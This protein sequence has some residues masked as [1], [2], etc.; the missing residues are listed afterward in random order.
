MAFDF[1]FFFFS[2][3][4]K[5]WSRSGEIHQDKY[6]RFYKEVIKYSTNIQILRMTT[7]N[8]A[9]KLSL[10]NLICYQKPVGKH[11]EANYK[12][13][14]SRLSKKYPGLKPTR[15]DIIRQLSEYYDLKGIEAL[16]KEDIQLDEAMELGITEHSVQGAESISDRISK[17]FHRDGDEEDEEEGRKRRKQ[18]RERSRSRVKGKK[19]SKKGKDDKNEKEVKKEVKT[20]GT[21]EEKKEDRGEDKVTKPAVTQQVSFTKPEVSKASYTDD[22]VSIGTRMRERGIRG[23][24]DE[25][26][27]DEETGK[28]GRSRTPKPVT[29][30]KTETG[31]ARRLR[32][33]SR[34]GVRTESSG[35]S[36]ERSR[37][38]SASAENS[39]GPASRTRHRKVPAKEKKIDK[40]QSVEKKRVEKK[41]VRTKED[42]GIANRT[43]RHLRK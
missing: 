20:E 5:S 29:G 27:E 37:S 25:E 14:A 35:R 3:S 24:S 33:S 32:S 18:S 13:I 22:S 43:R 11:R 26:S 7:W 17:R 10:L 12:A 4:E 42:G 6:S 23:R 36:R 34:S 41:Q 21:A 28:R 19:S 9:Q 1:F 8:L 38:R 16:D 15:A 31:I 30:H 2:R 39:E 40:K